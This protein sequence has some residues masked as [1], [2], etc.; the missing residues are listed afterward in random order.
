LKHYKEAIPVVK[1]FQASYPN[2]LGSGFC[3]TYLIVDYVELGRDQ[4]RRPS[5]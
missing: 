5:V 4:A 2:L 1:Q 3:F